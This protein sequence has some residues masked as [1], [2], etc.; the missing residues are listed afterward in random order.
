MNQLS[1]VTQFLLFYQRSNIASYASAGIAHKYLSVCLSVTFWYRDVH[2]LDSSID[3]I[4]LGPMTVRPPMYKIMTAYV[5]SQLNRPRVYYVIISDY[6]HI[7]NID[8]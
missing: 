1:A 6:L 7:L 2:G 5:F 8:Y 4:G 3:W